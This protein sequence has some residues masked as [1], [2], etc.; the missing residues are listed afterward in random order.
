MLSAVSGRQRVRS[1]GW[2]VNLGKPHGWLG[3]TCRESGRFSTC[4]ARHGAFS[5][6]PTLPR[7]PAVERWPAMPVS[8]DCRGMCHDARHVASRCR[9]PESA[10][11]AGCGASLGTG[12]LCSPPTPTT[13]VT[14]CCGRSDRRARASRPGWPPSSSASIVNASMAGTSTRWCRCRCTGSE[15]RLVGPV[16]PTRSRGAWR[17]ALDCPADGRSGERDAHACRTNC[18]SRSDT[19]ISRGLFAQPGVWRARGCCWWTT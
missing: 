3:Q 10:S 1:A 13:F 8:R 6:M 11:V 7:R 2:T 16:P 15:G 14:S 5:A 12:W 4:C 18:P 17:R 9:A 19:R